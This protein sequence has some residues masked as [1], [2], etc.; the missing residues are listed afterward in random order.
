M[1]SGSDQSSPAVTVEP[2]YLIILYVSIKLLCYNVSLWYG[3]AA[4]NAVIA[5]GG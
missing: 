3:T 2:Y 5:E 4:S 1:I